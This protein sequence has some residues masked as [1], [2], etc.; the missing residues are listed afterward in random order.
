MN[1]FPRTPANQAGNKMHSL[2]WID[3]LSHA[4]S[5]GNSEI[6]ASRELPNVSPRKRD[7]IYS[8]AASY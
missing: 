6:I 5:G 3:G 8:C 2:E 4:M 7:W 1:A